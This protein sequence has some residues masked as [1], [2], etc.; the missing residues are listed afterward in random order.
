MQVCFTAS[1]EVVDA[2]GRRARVQGASGDDE[3]SE[4]GGEMTG[5]K[6][7]DYGNKGF[8]EAKCPRCGS[9]RTAVA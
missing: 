9:K 7:L 3:E 4:E 2:L 8:T 1:E 6:C 5:R